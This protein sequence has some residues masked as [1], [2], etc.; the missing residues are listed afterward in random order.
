MKFILILVVVLAAVGSSSATP[1]MLI[2]PYR[3]FT[4]VNA[5][6]ETIAVIDLEAGTLTFGPGAPPTEAAKDVWR[7]LARYAPKCP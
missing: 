2:D 5:R 4:F 1:T 3:T 7:V 6:L